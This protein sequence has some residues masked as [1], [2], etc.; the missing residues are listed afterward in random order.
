MQLIP[1]IQSLLRSF[2]EFYELLGDKVY[3]FFIDYSRPILNVMHV[4]FENI[5]DVL[6]YIT[7][8]L[9]AAYAVI[10][11]YVF[12]KRNEADIEIPVS[13]EELPSITVKIP[14][15]NELAALNCARRALNFDYPEEKVQIIIGDDS[16]K[17]EVSK[18]ID[19]FA[20]AHERVEVTRRGS[21]EGY[22]PGNLNHMLKFTDGDY[23]LIFDSDFLPRKDFARPIVAPFIHDDSVAAVQSRW[24]TR[25]LT[26][27]LVSLLGGLIPMYSHHLALPLI[28]RMN[29]NGF[30][31]GSAEAIRKKDLLELGGWTSGALTEDIEYS[32]RLTNAGRRIVYLENL[33][34]ECEAPFT[35][36]DL[37]K[38]QMR[39][40]YGVIRAGKDYF[41]KMLLNTRLKIS[42]KMNI[43]L[44]LSGYLITGLFFLLAATGLLSLITHEPEVI[45]WV[46]MFSETG[47]NILLTSGFIIASALT[48]T[49][50]DHPKRIPRM[51]LA[52][53]TVGIVVIL[54]V[55][56]GI[57]KAIFN[58][59]M[60]WFMLSKK[61]NEV[62]L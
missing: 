20:A 1:V 18:R 29:G 33:H 40:S 30:I 42:H 22:K 13:D 7:V 39:W 16:N 60:Q 11:I 54:N 19:E 53:F 49:M 10:A 14:T 3:Q 34:C 59:P 43:F 26:Q 46:Q 48:I 57:T 31:A 12:L 47:L 5:F 45:I 58:R 51:I 27:N 52:T 35:M 38:Q 25:N 4:I 24:V 17:P 21:N 56:I 32:L 37:R 55:S 61:G 9:T 28:N 2:L 62:K 36:D 8:G 50:G 6:L 15:Y 44:L 41:S 23:I